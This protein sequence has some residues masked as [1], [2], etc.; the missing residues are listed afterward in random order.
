MVKK[1]AAQFKVSDRTLYHWV[2]SYQL[3][4]LFQLTAKKAK[5]LSRK[6]ISGWIAKYIN[7]MRDDYNWGAEVVQIHLLYDF[8]MSIYRWS[9]QYRR[10]KPLGWKTANEILLDFK[11]NNYRHSVKAGTKISNPA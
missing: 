1:V 10:R 11:L 6:I 5:G 8:G 2:K 7:D 9:N 4:G 3:G